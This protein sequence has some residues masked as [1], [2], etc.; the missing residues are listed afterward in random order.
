MK[1]VPFILA[2]MLG[3][4]DAALVAGIVL[5]FLQ[6]GTPADAAAADSQTAAWSDSFESN[7][8][9]YQ[10][11]DRKTEYGGIV[12]AGCGLGGAPSSEG[13]TSAG[14]EPVPT[15][16]GG[17]EPTPTPGSTQ[18]QDSDF[19][20]PS[21]DTTL[22]TE[23]EMRQKL[24]SAEL[25]QRAVNEIYAR[26]GYQFHEDKNPVDY[27]YFNSKAWYQALPKY[28]N[29]EDVRKLFNSTEIANV[30]ALMAF[31]EAQGWN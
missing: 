25:C 19:I 28:E 8:E 12:Q 21:S 2:I 23:A 15:L 3:V 5:L 7:E 30:D 11:E 17:T 22:I 6:S 18:M 1:K 20:F 9:T 26:H 16:P 31:K 24:T 14:N 27:A 13:G 10:N 4:L 29:Q